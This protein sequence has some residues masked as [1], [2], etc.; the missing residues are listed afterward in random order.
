MGA[1]VEEVHGPGHHGVGLRVGEEVLLVLPFRHLLPP[2]AG[3]L[4]LALHDRPDGGPVLGPG[5]Q[6]RVVVA[7]DGHVHQVPAA[8]AVAVEVGGGDGAEDAGE[9]EARLALVGDGGQGQALGHVGGGALG[10]LLHAAH[11]DHVVEPGGDGEDALAEGDGAGGAGALGAR[12]RLGDHAEG[13]GEDGTPVGLA[14]EEV[15]GEVAEVEG[16]DVARV[17]ALVDGGEHRL[18]GLGEEVLGVAFGEDAE[19]GH[20]RSHH[21][22]AAAESAFLRHSR[23]S[24]LVRRPAAPGPASRAR[25]AR[26]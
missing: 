9:G 3:A 17:D 25:A 24:R 20:A 7:L 6:R 22:H 11:Q 8:G 13:V 2:A 19:A 4:G 23:C 12:R 5:V 1:A 21:G 10:H 14:G 18:E 16:V 26:S 15:V